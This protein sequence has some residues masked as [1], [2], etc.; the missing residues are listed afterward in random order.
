MKV[1]SWSISCLGVLLLLA[2]CATGSVQT[3]RL[4]KPSVY[5]SLPPEQRAMVDQGQISIGMPMDA[6]YIAWGKPAQILQGESANGKT[7]TWLFHG[8]TWEEH[9]YWTQRPYRHGRNSYYDTTLERDYQPREFVSSEVIF[10]AG[11]VKSWR[12]LQ[13]PA[14]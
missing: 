9:R 6:V 13:R 11:V 14:N 1:L 8:T 4:E 3:R 2:G 10:E 5:A 7:T 12:N